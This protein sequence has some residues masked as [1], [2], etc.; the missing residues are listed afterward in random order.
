MSSR[1]SSSVIVRPANGWAGGHARI[2]WSEKN[3][4]NRTPRWRRAAPTIPSSSSRAA[5]RSTTEW[6]SDTVRKTR[7]SG[8]WRWNSASATGI[9]TAAG[10]VDA[11]STRSPA[12]A[13]S[14]EAA[15]SAT[16]WPSSA[17]MRCAPRYSR[18]PASVGSTRRPERSSSC[19]PSRFS[20]ARTCSETAGCVTPSRSAACEKLRRSTTAQ[21]AASWRVSI[22]E[23][24]P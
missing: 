4:S 15:T 16:S 17:S 20:R 12:S 1:S 11:P 8:F 18:Q 24:Y 19:V 22:S 10:P 21:N 5:T 14:P 13:P 6:V 9:A 7:T 2:T 3:G 23:P